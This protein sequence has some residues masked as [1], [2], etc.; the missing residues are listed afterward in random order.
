M[1]KQRIIFYILVLFSALFV[2]Q[3]S[4][5]ALETYDFSNMYSYFKSLNFKTPASPNLY[6]KDKL[7]ELVSALNTISNN[8]S[9]KEFAVVL[10]EFSASSSQNPSIYIY[11]I[12][13]VDTVLTSGDDTMFRFEKKCNCWYLWLREYTPAL[14]D[15]FISYITEHG[16]LPA[17]NYSNF[18]VSSSSIICWPGE[19]PGT[20]ISVLYYTTKPLKFI[21]G[22]Y[23]NVNFGDY[24][25]T[26]N[27]TFITYKEFYEPTLNLKNSFNSGTNGSNLGTVFWNINAGTDSKATDGVIR[28]RIQYGSNDF[29]ASNV[30]VLDSYTLYGL[31][32]LGEWIEITDEEHYI[33]DLKVTTDS[34]E[35]VVESTLHIPSDRCIYEKMYVKFNFSNTGN[36]YMYVY[37]DLDDSSWDMQEIYL[38]G[39]RR[40]MFPKDK[41]YAFITSSS[42]D[43]LK[44]NVYVPSNHII[45]PDILFSAYVYDYV[46]NDTLEKLSSLKFETDDYYSYFSF[47]LSFSNHQVLMLQRKKSEE[48]VYFYVPDSYIV[49]FFSSDEQSQIV[50]PDGP[51]DIFVDD[52]KNPYDVD[53]DYGLIQPL[54]DLFFSKF[55]IVNQIGEIIDSIR[56]SANNTTKN[57]DLNPPHFEFDLSGIGINSKVPLDFEFFEE[58]RGIVFF[59]IKLSLGVVTFS[60]C[61]SYLFKLPD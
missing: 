15:T 37:D 16:D 52:I 61:L 59:I 58:Y 57:K 49:K 44:G 23:D 1:S 43:S 6:Y 17:S 34:S 27:S 32:E 60:K 22:T 29:T 46:Q 39:Y 10:G 48:N 21:G 25:I 26:T 53:K 45:N 40:Y 4:V 7:D 55:P 14:I 56:S 36:Y 13:D 11:D 12:S 5:H 51:V 18:Q 2:H 24:L 8:D 31:N 50:T 9:T 42:S 35:T 41:K 47:D 3:P 54:I 33:D 38:N 30:P 28:F 19:S 20:K